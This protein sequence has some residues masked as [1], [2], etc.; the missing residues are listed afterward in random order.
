MSYTCKRCDLELPR[1][2]FYD[3]IFMK[4]RT[5]RACI[6]VAGVAVRALGAGRICHPCFIAT[7]KGRAMNDNIGCR[8]CTVTYKKCMGCRKLCKWRNF[9]GDRCEDCAQYGDE[10]AVKG[11]YVSEVIETC[12]PEA[13]ISPR[14]RIVRISQRGQEIPLSP[15]PGES[16]PREGV[17]SIMIRSRREEPPRPRVSVHE[18]RKI[19]SR[20]EVKPSVQPVH[21]PPQPTAPL[22]NVKFPDFNAMNKM[23][24]IQYVVKLM[25]TRASEGKAVVYP[26]FNGTRESIVAFAFTELLV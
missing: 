25:T 16:S 4:T 20:Q 15:E 8:T 12:S 9:H 26:D 14:H 7:N 17:K 1:C 13:P 5:C 23:E 3:Q 2:A 19:A 24:V 18:E 11:Y 10:D 22:P 6:S 21:V